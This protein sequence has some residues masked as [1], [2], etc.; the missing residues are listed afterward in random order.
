MQCTNP[1]NY[2]PD[3]NYLPMIPPCGK[4]LA[5]LT[6][7]R[8]EWASRLMLEGTAHD[9]IQFVTLTYS[10]QH[11]PESDLQLKR[12][13]QNFRK[14]L[15]RVDG[16]APRYYAC[17]E[18]GTLYGRAH[19]HVILFGRRSSFETRLTPE[20]KKYRVD[21]VIEDT[22]KKG[23]TYS[24]DC[25]PGQQAA[26][27]SRYVVNYLLKNTWTENDKEEEGISPEFSLKSRRPYIG[28]PAVKW[29][30]E[31]IGTRRG[32]LRCMHLGT[33]PDKVHLAG[34]VWKIPLRIRKEVAELTDQPLK[35]VPHND[36]TVVVF[37]NKSI[38][39]GKPQ[40]SLT[41][42]EA[43]INEQRLGKRIERLKKK[44][45]HRDGT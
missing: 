44:A 30:S 25:L 22:W 14:K 28:K 3:G 39:V 12:D 45:G 18:Y 42:A 5:C 6:T 40:I 34:K 19:W 10:E 26:N 15:T 13:F 27:I 4:C 35:Q 2:D 38:I 29:L 31:L 8:Y 41:R 33:I 24:K 1:G 17:M 16:H 9:H 43:E 21:P 20:G 32:L 7:R 36:S 23:L 37:H 11:L